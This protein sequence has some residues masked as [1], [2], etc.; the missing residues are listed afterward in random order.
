MIRQV[1][2][3]TP[4]STNFAVDRLDAGARDGA[5]RFADAG[6]LGDAQGADW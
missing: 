3:S 5:A 2:E 4:I 1:K 6:D